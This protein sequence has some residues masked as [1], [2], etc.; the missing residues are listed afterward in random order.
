[1]ADSKTMRAD[2]SK[3]LEDKIA[4]KADAQGATETHGENLDVSSKKLKGAQGQLA[5]LH[6]DCDWLITLYTYAHVYMHMHTWVLAN[7]R[8]VAN[9]K[10]LNSCLRCKFLLY[11]Q[12]QQHFKIDELWLQNRGPPK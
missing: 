8:L 4:A 2:N 6:Q 1:M 9:T 11:W 7:D 5:V 12:P 10:V 3:I